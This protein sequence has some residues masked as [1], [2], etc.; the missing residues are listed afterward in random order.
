MIGMKQFAA[1]SL[2]LFVLAAIVLAP[3]SHLRAQVG[4]E[5]V[6]ATPVP[7]SSAGNNSIYIPFEKLKEVFGEEGATAVMPYLD[8]QKLWK[9]LDQQ[10]KDKA[11]EAVIVQADYA[12]SVEKSVA[13]VTATLKL[14]ALKAGWSSVPLPFGQASIGKLTAG[15]ERILLRGTGPGNYEL[16]LPD[17][18]NYDVSLELFSKVQS[19]PDGQLLHFTCPNV[20]IASVE[21]TV[22]ETEQTIQM[23]P[24][25][26]EMPVEAP[27]GQSRVKFHLGSTPNV[28]ITWAPRASAKPLMELL[29]SVRNQTHVTLADGLIHTR[30]VLDIDVLR[31]ELTQVQIDVPKGDRI[32]DV[33]AP[34]AKV[35]GWKAVEGETSQTITV[36]LLQA[37]EKTL[38]LEVHTERALPE[39]NAPLAGIAED[40]TVSGIHVRDAIRE[41]GYIAVTHSED[42]QLVV[43]K[44]EGLIRVDAGEVPDALRIA[45][46]VTYRFYSPKFSLVAGIKPVEPR[47]RVVN[48]TQLSF[49]PGELFVRGTL[50]YVVER[51]GVFELK[52]KLPPNLKIDQVVTD[53]MREFTIDDATGTLTVSFLE[54]RI[55]NV[56]VILNGKVKLADSGEEKLGLPI[57]EPLNPFQETG[58]ILVYAPESLEVITEEAETSGAHAESVDGSRVGESRLVGRWTYQ[59]RPVVITVRTV[60]KPT[61]LTASQATVVEIREDQAKLTMRLTYNVEHAPVRTF[62]VAVPEANSA[63]INIEVPPNLGQP[64]QHKSPAEAAE[65]GWIT[66]TIE[67]QKDVLGTQT[68]EITYTVDLKREGDQQSAELK[69]SLPRVLPSLSGTVDKVEVPVLR[70]TGEITVEKDR[71]LS[72]SAEVEADQFERIDVRE[73]ESLTGRGDVAFRYFSQPVTITVQSKKHEIQSVVETVVSRALVEVAIGYDPTAT[74]RCRYRLASSERQRLMVLLPKNAQPLSVL[75]D[76]AL[77][78]LEKADASEST[79]RYDAY[80][81]NVTRSKSSNEEFSLTLQFQWRINPGQFKWPLGKMELILPRIASSGGDAAVQ[82]MRLAVWIPDRFY[83]VGTPHPFHA[84]ASEICPGEAFLRVPE[85]TP[86]NRAE[87]DGWI[88]N[89]PTGTI[90]FPDQG[91][92]YSYQALGDVST[93]RVTWWDLHYMVWVL[94]GAVF[95]IGFLLRSTSWENR[96]GIVLLVVFAAALYAVKEI[97]TVA[98]AIA[99]ARFGI[100]AT[101]ALWLIQCV[102]GLRRGRCETP[103]TPTPPAPTGETPAPTAS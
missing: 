21:I 38:K 65:E 31:G 85:S 29:T 45:N 76:G 86:V 27:A 81:V 58:S 70:T 15:D 17:R 69:Q 98:Y 100:Y 61:R 48:A 42:A 26:V 23:K 41:S 75:V 7:E 93:T 102:C 92:A 57:P 90:E 39:G 3:T 9:L 44:Q 101:L 74:F 33:S 64:I 89:V 35:R 51:A 80:Y 13:R 79:D 83:L 37:V 68:F 30:A 73:L 82:Q 28:Q 14:K 40:G 88:G 1:K 5:T 53:R 99:A 36:D 56:Q 24:E 95:V 43:E 96:L 67:T 78:E 66:W 52:I 4:D 46:S 8:L 97:D 10:G 2:T 50:D 22:P 6:P 20:G 47:I 16:L 18:G 71:S 62:R 34:Q 19:S 12:V 63:K 25:G 55:G 84:G 94:S 103:A 49:R 11:P 59:R 87:L 72:V 91:R 32:L 54:K 77:V 60:R